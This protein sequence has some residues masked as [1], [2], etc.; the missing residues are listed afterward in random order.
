MSRKSRD[1]K[2]L[3]PDPGQLKTGSNGNHRDRR[4]Q[5]RLFAAAWL[6]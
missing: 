3:M 2:D 1:R 4:R 5:I 6:R